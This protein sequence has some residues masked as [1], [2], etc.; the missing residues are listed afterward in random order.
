[1]SIRKKQ[2]ESIFKFLN[3]NVFIDVYITERIV[4]EHLYDFC[5]DQYKFEQTTFKMAFFKIIN[6]NKF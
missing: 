1:M 6:L 5:T 4:F 3:Q 2:S